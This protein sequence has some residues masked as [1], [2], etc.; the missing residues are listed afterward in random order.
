M[1]REIPP[2]GSDPRERGPRPLTAGSRHA[3]GWGSGPD[4]A[5]SGRQGGEGA[6]AAEG[7]TH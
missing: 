5:R 6:P 3:P 2:R 4:L 1:G 7:L